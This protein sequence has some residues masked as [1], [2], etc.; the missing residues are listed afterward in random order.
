MNYKDT[1]NQEKRD[2]IYKIKKALQNVTFCERECPLFCF[3]DTVDT[4][5]DY[6]EE[7]DNKL[8]SE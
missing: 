4:I 1:L 3:C 5:C 6:L 7:L 8:V 2:S